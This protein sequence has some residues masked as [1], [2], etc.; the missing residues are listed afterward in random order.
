MRSRCA[1]CEHYTCTCRPEPKQSIQVT[2]ES[3]PLIKGSAGLSE[4][5]ET[6]T[7]EGSPQQLDDECA[8]RLPQGDC[9]GSTVPSPSVPSKEVSPGNYAHDCLVVGKQ[10]FAGLLT[11]GQVC[12]LCGWAAPVAPTSKQDPRPCADCGAPSSVQHVFINAYFCQACSEKRR[13][14]SSTQTVYQ[15]ICAIIRGW[16]HHWTY[17][18]PGYEDRGRR[19][20][21]AN[22]VHDLARRLTEMGPPLVA[23]TAEQREGHLCVFVDGVDCQCGAKYAAFKAAPAD[24]REALQ[25]IFDLA[26]RG[27]ATEFEYHVTAIARDALATTRPD[28][29]EERESDGKTVAELRDFYDKWGREDGNSPGYNLQKAKLYGRQARFFKLALHATWEDMPEGPA[30]ERAREALDTKEWPEGIDAQWRSKMGPSNTMCCVKC[31]APE[32]EWVIK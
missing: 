29:Q 2:Q 7:R 19:V 18:E 6:G 31:G 17:N 30:R 24:Y 28:N 13:S 21:D 26:G 23:P 11:A 12:C 25:K 32:G 8:K 14:P 10:G 5:E 27:T 4:A 9:Q 16:A 15:E 3:Y 1:Y 20:A 22:M